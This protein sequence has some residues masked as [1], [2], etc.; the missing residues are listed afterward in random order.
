MFMLPIA[1]P[2]M[3]EL[4]FVVCIDVLVFV[5]S[6]ALAFASPVFVLPLA[7]RRAPR[8][9]RRRV[10][11]PV[12]VFCVEPDV[13]ALSCASADTSAPAKTTATS[14]AQTAVRRLRACFLRVM[15]VHPPGV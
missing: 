6:D 3:F 7:M 10:V 1:P 2:D 9:P 5:V 15:L 14:N 13:L 8:R 4:S 12:F 11:V